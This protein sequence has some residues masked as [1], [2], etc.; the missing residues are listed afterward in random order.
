MKLQV[1]AKAFITPGRT[2]K[3]RH[4]ERDETVTRIGKWSIPESHGEVTNSLSAAPKENKRV[5]EIGCVNECVGTVKSSVTTQPVIPTAV[6]V[7]EA[8]PCLENSKDLSICTQS[9]DPSSP[10]THEAARLIKLSSP[11]CNVQHIF[12]I[13]IYIYSNTTFTDWTWVSSVSQLQVYKGAPL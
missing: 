11:C 2:S 1:P 13:Y 8:V 7:H 9:H 5:L 10:S 12:Y 3:R 4:G 6:T